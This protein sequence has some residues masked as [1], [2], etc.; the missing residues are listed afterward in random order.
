MA[1]DDVEITLKIP[2][3]YYDIA[4]E[5]ESLPEVKT[6]NKGSMYGNIQEVKQYHKNHESF[7]KKVKEIYKRDKI[8]TVKERKAVYRAREI[9]WKVETLTRMDAIK[10]PL[11]AI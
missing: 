2:K 3:R 8:T 5:I 9:L 11:E 1:S 4:M 7:E 6:K 10:E